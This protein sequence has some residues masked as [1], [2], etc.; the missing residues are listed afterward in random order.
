MKLIPKVI[1]VFKIQFL[2]NIFTDRSPDTDKFRL[3]K[4]LLY[5]ETTHPLEIFKDFEKAANLIYSKL[6]INLLQ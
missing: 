3:F 4:I 5:H 1:D 2:K 6:R